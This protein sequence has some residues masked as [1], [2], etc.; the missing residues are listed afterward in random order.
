M[1]IIEVLKALMRRLLIAG[2]RMI[3]ALPDAI[4]DRNKGL[5]ITTEGQEGSQARLAAPQGLPREVRE[6]D[7]PVN[8]QTLTQVGEQQRPHGAL[9][10][11]IGH[12]RGLGSLVGKERGCC[13]PIRDE[14]AV[15]NRPS[16]WRA[17]A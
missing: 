9:I 2:K 11:L 13:H 15:L 10:C 12:L 4:R 14:Q 8:P 1:F 6:A 3:K 7:I 5:L 16:F 17:G